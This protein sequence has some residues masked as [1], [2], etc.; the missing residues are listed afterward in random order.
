[1]NEFCAKKLG[2]VL[3][4]EYFGKATFA[5]GREALSTLFS[6]G[7]I[8]HVNATYEDFITRIESTATR[9]NVSNVTLPKKDKT[10]AKLSQMQDLY[11]G[12]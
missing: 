10:F 3:A 1:M 2:E 4:F 11:V 12:D 6:Q 5:K 7:I 9:N 8:E